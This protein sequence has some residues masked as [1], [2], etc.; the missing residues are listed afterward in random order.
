MR[1]QGSNSAPVSANPAQDAGP[2]S[3]PVEAAMQLDIAGV[4]AAKGRLEKTQGV[5]TSLNSF[6]GLIGDLGSKLD[7]LKTP[8]SF[9]KLSFQSSHPDILDGQITGLALPGSY[10]FE[11]R[12][13]ARSD[14]EL[15]FGFPDSDKTSIGFGHMEIERADL[16]PMEIT[17]QPGATL[18]D[19]ANQINAAE[20]GVRAMVINTGAQ[21][22]PF[23]LMVMS[24]ASGQEA[25]INIDPDTTF[26]D[27]KKQVVG[28][29]LD[30]KFEDVDVARKDNAVADLLPGVSI[31]AKKAEPG[32]RVQV[33]VSHDVDKTYK[34]IQEFAD[35]YNKVASFAN[36]Q[37]KIDP[38]T[39]KAGELSGE[40]SVRSV[41]R[42]LQSQ[43]G[44]ASTGAV[45]GGP[46]SL[47]EIGITTNPK[48]GELM[49]DE[50]KV[51]AALAR[52][53]E[54]VSKLFVRSESG[55]GLADR[56]SAAVA[57]MKNS[58]NGI[59]TLRQKSLDAQIQ[60]QDKQINQ[61]MDRVDQKRKSVEASIASLNVKMANMN[62]QQQFLAARLPGGQSEA[63]S[64]V[65]NQGGGV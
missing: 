30:L 1:I 26:T 24:E 60:N 23:R 38:D 11:V 18:N 53:Y 35:Q 49:M 31:N 9:G 4:A 56:M 61:Q 22:M 7:G 55:P 32:T 43:M 46:Q 52:N 59:L 63:G 3:A 8:Q 14:K 27:F 36:Q 65:N 58:Q 20:G 6:A 28:K 17:I 29:N 57:A 64:N 48:T 45:A 40:S 5:K 44:S 2:R 21:E 25:R 62:S 33:N 10:E 54:G 47:A 42:S 37:V 16:G 15:A 12:G 19:V 51:K 39:G 41:M 13:L 50:S 34:G